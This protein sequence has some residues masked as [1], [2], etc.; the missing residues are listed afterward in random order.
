MFAAFQ[1][2]PRRMQLRRVFSLLSEDADTVWIHV[3]MPGTWK[4]HDAG[5]FTL[6]R[7]DFA[8][9]IAN[10]EHQKNDIP[11]DWEHA[12]EWAAQAPAAGWVKQLRLQGDNLW[13][14][15]EL[16]KKAAS[17]IRAGEYRFSSGVFVFDATDRATG[18][19]CGCVLHSLALTN[20][21]FIDGQQSIRLRA[22]AR[23]ARLMMAQ[24]DKAKLIEAITELDGDALD[25]Q[26]VLAVAEGLALLE[27]AKKAP[28]E[29]EEPAA[30]ADGA[31]VEEEEEEEDVVPASDAAPEDVVPAADAM[32]AIE[33]EG[34]AAAAALA[35]LAE[36][37]GTDIVGLAALIAEKVDE[38]AALLEG[39]GA[40]P[41]AAPFSDGAPEV[42]TSDAPAIPAAPTPTAVAAG[43]RAM[44]TTIRGLSQRLAVFE[45][46]EKDAE[47]AEAEGLVDDLVTSGRLLDGGRADMVTFALSNR[48]GF[49]RVAASLGQAVPTGVIAGPDTATDVDTTPINE[50]DAFVVS[51]RRTMK[52][53][54]GNTK[55]KEDA[56][57]RAHAK[58]QQDNGAA[59]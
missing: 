25:P 38:V 27:A 1:T 53:I 14:F 17:Q 45:K 56:A 13:A 50:A 51:L 26:Q 21:P 30:M 2:A 57:I 28:E 22:D 16:G 58:A 59:H 20:V 7:D 33:G 48:A 44:E 35:P 6:T 46:R 32:P 19:E 9:I 4:G 18:E 47:R 12:T 39:A 31:E 11:L 55:A 15:V 42:A 34:D 54:K 3:A 8:T 24:A 37:L 43:T 40:E 41:E 49:D 5:E 29:P 23:G 36:R 52:G 10:F